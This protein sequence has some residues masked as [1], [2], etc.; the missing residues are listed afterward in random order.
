[1]RPDII[2]LAAGVLDEL[3]VV[4]WAD[5][6]GGDVDGA[7]VGPTR[8]L[9]STS[10]DARTFASPVDLGVAGLT[11]GISL[12]GAPGGLGA[13]WHDHVAP[14]S[15]P[16][17]SIWFASL[18]EGASPSLPV[19]VAEWDLGSGLEPTIAFADGRFGIVAIESEGLT[20][21][22][23][24]LA[25][26]NRDGTNGSGDAPVTLPAGVSATRLDLTWGGNA[27]ALVSPADAGM[28]E[29]DHILLWQLDS[30][31]ATRSGP[32]Q[33][34]EPSVTV[35]INRGGLRI[36]P[37]SHARYLVV[38]GQPTRDGPSGIWGAIVDCAPR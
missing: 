6:E 37:I 8:L 17:N 3:L 23:L 32:I 24:H 7:F 14:R 19:L 35:F 34:E 26:L 27:F 13:A 4:A 18:D 22:N 21:V 30:S 20:P 38:W 5:F 2:G 9:F 10:E 25:I 33:V 36:V 16:E 11:H 1:V 12:A 31:G 28:G 15:I 29:S